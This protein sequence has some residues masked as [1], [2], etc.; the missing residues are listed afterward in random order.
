MIRINCTFIFSMVLISSLQAQFS[1]E[2]YLSNSVQ[3]IEIKSIQN[4]Q[5]YLVESSFR[6]PILREV[7]FRMRANQFGEG[8]DDYR[9]RFSP[10]NPFERSANKN[11]S[12]VIEEQK[13]MEFRWTLNEVFKSRYGMMIK[14]FY[15]Y[16]QQQN[17]SK[18]VTFYNDLLSLARLRPNTYSVKDVIRTDRSIL[19]AQIKLA[20]LKGSQE[21][22]EYLINQTYSYAGE[23]TWDKNLLIKPA[24]ISDWLKEHNV[25]AI[26][27]N[28]FIQNEIKKGI[29]AESEFTIKKQES[30]SNI[31]YVQAE[32]REDAD[33]T[34]GQKL[35]IQVAMTIP[36]V[37]PDKPDLARRRLKMIKDIQE[38]E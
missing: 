26:D 29:L 9:L 5:Q 28:L 22:L 19:K 14:H 31:G 34:F 18:K 30:F 25:P 36:I 4:Q 35:G 8:L 38:L 3:A 12:A 2:K 23:L 33:N 10:L 6:S 15:L 24:Q 37:N 13:K 16:Q 32:Y 1:M 21:Q 7:E 11:Y 17:L 20:E 27:N